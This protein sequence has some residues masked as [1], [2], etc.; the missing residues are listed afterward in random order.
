M[1]R[2]SDQKIVAI[3]AEFF[4]RSLRQSFIEP[5]DVG[6][7]LGPAIQAKRQKTLFKLG[8]FFRRPYFMRLWMPWIFYLS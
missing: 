6:S 1:I 5:F 2:Q 4:I 7:G 8:H 3:T